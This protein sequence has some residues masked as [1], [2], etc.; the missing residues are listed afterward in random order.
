MVG[1]L[2]L[3]LLLIGGSAYRYGEC[4]KK[5]EKGWYYIAIIVYLLAILAYRYGLK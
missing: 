2:W 5:G 3:I 1:G 4:K